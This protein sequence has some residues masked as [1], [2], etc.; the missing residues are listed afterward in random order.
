MPFYILICLGVVFPVYI[1][2]HYVLP[3]EFR[4]MRDPQEQGLFLSASFF[5]LSLLLLVLPERILIKWDRADLEWQRSRWN[6]DRSRFYKWGKA[7]GD[8]AALKRWI[9]GYRWGGLT[10]LLI[11][12]LI[13]LLLGVDG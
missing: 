12:T 10:C 13:L 9:K 5:T 4:G 6:Y 8:K 3:V 1:M 7:Y 2:L 11:A